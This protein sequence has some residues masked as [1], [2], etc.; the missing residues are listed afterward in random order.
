MPDSPRCRGHASRRLRRSQLT[1]P[2][3]AVPPGAL[4]TPPAAT[5]AVAPRLFPNRRAVPQAWHARAVRPKHTSTSLSPPNTGHFGEPQADKEIIRKPHAATIA[6]T[7]PVT[8]LPE[9]LRRTT[10]VAYQGRDSAA[11][12]HVS[13]QAHRPHGTDRT[14]THLHRAVFICIYGPSSISQ[15]APFPPHPLSVLSVISVA[16]VMPGRRFHAFSRTAVPYPWRGI[17]GP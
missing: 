9:P 7:V 2:P 11:Q 4:I 5:L 16:A 1:I 15:P 10:G 6:V 8:P 14:R 17:P 13:H 3:R 12:W